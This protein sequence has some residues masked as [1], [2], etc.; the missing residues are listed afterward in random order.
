MFDFLK[1]LI[2]ADWTNAFGQSAP[3]QGVEWS[4]QQYEQP[5]NFDSFE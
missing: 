5:S 3:N 2:P 4:N 1:N